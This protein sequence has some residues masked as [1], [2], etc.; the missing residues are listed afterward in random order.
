MEQD[1]S[2]NLDAYRAKKH[3]LALKPRYFE[4]FEFRNGMVDGKRHTYVETGK[5]FGISGVRVSQIIARVEYE[6]GKVL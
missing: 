6:L 2:A 4:I 1:R 5:R 3:L